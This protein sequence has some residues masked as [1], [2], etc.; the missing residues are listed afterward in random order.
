MLNVGSSLLQDLP[1]QKE[2]RQVSVRD[3]LVVGVLQSRCHLS[4]D[5]CHLR[6]RLKRLEMPRLG[7]RE[8]LVLQDILEEVTCT[9]RI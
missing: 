8:P 6:R 1:A 4:E 7:F 2:V 5:L 9:S 3:A